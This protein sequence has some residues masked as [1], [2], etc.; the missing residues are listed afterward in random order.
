VASSFV[1][2][3]SD[4]RQFLINATAA[5]GA[6]CA[7][8][9]VYP[10]LASMAPSEAAKSAG[11]PVEADIAHLRAGELLTVG[12]RGK[13]TWILHRSPDMI[14]ALNGHDDLLADPNSHDSQQPA[15]CANPGRSQRPEVFV[16]LGVCTHLGC[17][18]TLR[19]DADARAQLGESWPGGFLCPCH[20]SKFDLAGRVFKGV[21]APINLEVPPYRYL[22]DSRLLIGDDQPA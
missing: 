3:P 6:A 10:L 18:P 15:N 20:G 8:A 12:W 1:V 5:A 13:P 16:C 7:A 9:T 21:P 22:S 4:R 2:Q 19:V 11:A 14:A 17:S